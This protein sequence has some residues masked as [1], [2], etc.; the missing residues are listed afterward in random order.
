MTSPPRFFIVCSKSPIDLGQIPDVLRDKGCCYE[1][2]FRHNK[3]QA[4]EY[5]V[6]FGPFSD[7][8]KCYCPDRHCGLILLSEG[9]V[10][11][12]DERCKPERD[13]VMAAVI[14]GKGVLGLCHGA[15]LL[16]Y[17][18]SGIPLRK[19]KKYCEQGL[20][21]LEITTNWHQDKLLAD[22]QKGVKG[23]AGVRNRFANVRGKPGGSRGQEPFRERNRSSAAAIQ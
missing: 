15:Q 9:C 10:Y 17:C 12:D 3:N 22:I 21:K 14:N 23:E 19:P 13:W 5:S 11:A 2:V 4:C 20:V 16:A 6:P 18:Y 8:P 7:N 1:G